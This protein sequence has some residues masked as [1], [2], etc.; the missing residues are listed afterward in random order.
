MKDR[1]RQEQGFEGVEG[2]LASGGPAPRQVLLGEINEGSGNIGVVRNKASEEVG[3][4][5]ERSDIFDFL[6][7]RPA[8]NTV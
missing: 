1:L 2:G 7:G 4:A 3:E 6:G 8:G 5:K